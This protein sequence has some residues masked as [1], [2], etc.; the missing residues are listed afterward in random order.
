MQSLGLFGGGAPTVASPGSMLLLWPAL[1]GIPPFLVVLVLVGLFFSWR[2]SLFSGQPAIPVRTVTLLVV[3]TVL[4]A[5]A[6]VAGWKFG[7]EY[8]GPDYVQLCLVLSILMLA[9]CT[10]LL[11]IG[12][13]R[14]SFRTSLAL[15]T[16]LFAWLA[17][18]AFPYLGETP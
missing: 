14:P 11:W 9:A 3:A 17:S 8:Q 13:R 10:A 4:S 15:Q 2:P 18:Y 16:V 6:F 7:Y 12:Y 5:V 1:M